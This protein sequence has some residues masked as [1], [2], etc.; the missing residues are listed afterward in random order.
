[1]DGPSGGKTLRSPPEPFGRERPG[2]NKGVNIMY[3]VA[4]LVNEK[5]EYLRELSGDD[6]F[7]DDIGN[8]IIY[9]SKDKAPALELGEYIIRVIQDDEG[10]IWPDPCK[11]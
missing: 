10:C 5:E 7:S 2:E 8:A 4:L 9:E 6:C 1:M 11:D 3:A